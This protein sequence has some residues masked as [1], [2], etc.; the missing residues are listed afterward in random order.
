MYASH[1]WKVGTVS[2]L[3]IDNV[4][5]KCFQNCYDIGNSSVLNIVKSIKEGEVV[6]EKRFNDN[7]TLSP[8]LINMLLKLAAARGL[9][10]PQ[11]R[12][13]MLRI[14]NS[15]SSLTCYAWLHNYFT[16]VGDNIPNSAGEIHLEPIEIKEIWKE[17]K[18]D[19]EYVHESFVSNIEFG[20]LWRNC[21]PHVKIREFKAV[22]G[23]VL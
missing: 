14:P 5:R 21:Y 17:Y 8:P 11:S 13:A 6:V 4:C 23:D 15:P 18:D 22:T 1:Q 3:L 20:S 19:M 2:T 16:L 12:I 7:T 9:T 10:I